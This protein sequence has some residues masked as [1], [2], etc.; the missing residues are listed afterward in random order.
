MIHPRLD[1]IKVASQVIYVESRAE[2]IVAEGFHRR[3]LPFRFLRP[4]PAQLCAH[5]IVPIGKDIGFHAHFIA[6]HSLDRKASAIDLRL[7]T[8][9]DD[10]RSSVLG[11][12]LRAVHGSPALLKMTT[13]SGGNVAAIDW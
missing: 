11:L 4:P 2:A 9:D 5:R 10:A 13:E 1:C 8:L 12:D 3:A 7:D 6:D